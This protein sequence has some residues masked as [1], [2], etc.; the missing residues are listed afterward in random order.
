MGEL[1]REQVSEKINQLNYPEEEPR[2]WSAWEQT[3]AA[4][5]ST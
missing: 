2:D 3:F 4:E 5:P 1:G